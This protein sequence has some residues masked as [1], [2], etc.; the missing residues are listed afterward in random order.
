MS[1]LQENARFALEILIRDLRMAGY[2]GCSDSIASLENDITGAGDDDSI[3]SFVNGLEGSEAAAAWKPSDGAI[4]VVA[5]AGTDAVTVRFLEPLSVNLGADMAAVDDPLTV[6]AVT[7]FVAGDL[8]AVSDCDSSDIMEATEVTVSGGVETIKHAT[9]VSTAGSPGNADDSLSKLYGTTAELMRFVTRRYYIGNGANGPGLMMAQGY[10]A[11]QELI[12]GVESMQILYGE[13]TTADQVVDAFVNA[14]SVA[15]WDNVIAVRVAL[16]LRTVEEGQHNEVDTDTY[17]L[18][19]T[20]VNPTDDRR[21][22]RTFSAT[23]QI[24]NRT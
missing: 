12:E 21:R 7:G 20:T 15:N 4:G 14:A 3:L 23:I 24:R 6:N 1:R 5:V 17:N 2:A 9:G 19:G 11:A 22:R 8:I 16:L 18:L 10:G 13:D